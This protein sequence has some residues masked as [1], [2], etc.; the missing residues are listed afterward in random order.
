MRRRRGIALMDALMAMAVLSVVVL[1][2]TY[3]TTAGHQHLRQG[4]QTLRA[5]RLA[6]HLMEEI[7]SRPYSGSDTS[8]RSA[9]HLGDYDGFSE[10]IGEL[11]DF[12]GARYAAEE[13]R[14]ARSAK[15]TDATHTLS[16]LGSL[17][18]SGKRV[19]VAITDRRGQSWTLERFVPEPQSP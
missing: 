5:V 11:T 12:S 1:G 13:Q 15:V 9:F 14:F 19:T 17:S 16:G 2:V 7:V 18:V 10:E 8:D 6:E 4:D 3:A